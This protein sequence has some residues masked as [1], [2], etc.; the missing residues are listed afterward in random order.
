MSDILIHKYID[1]LLSDHSANRKLEEAEFACHVLVALTKVE[2]RREVWALPDE[3]CRP[4][5]AR[6]LL[7][8]FRSGDIAD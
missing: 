4:V 2:T 8:L 7:V 6:H 5:A 3:R 1:A